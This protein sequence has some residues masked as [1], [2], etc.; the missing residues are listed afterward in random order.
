MLLGGGA[1]LGVLLRSTSSDVRAFGTWPAPCF[2]SLGGMRQHI[3]PAVAA[4][5]QHGNGDQIGE[6]GGHGNLAGTAD[7]G[8]TAISVPIARISPQRL[9]PI[10][11]LL[12]R[13]VGLRQQ[14]AHGEE[15]V[16]LAGEGAMG[17]GH[18]GGFQP[19]R[20]FLAFVAQRSAPAVMT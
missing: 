13:D 4:T 3:K 19:L 14:L 6:Q 1:A 8:P 20:I 10:A 18:A 12:D 2:G 9:Q 17:G 11:D 16:E 5:Q 15:A 7:N